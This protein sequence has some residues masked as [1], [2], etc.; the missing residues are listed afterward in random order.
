[1]IRARCRW[2]AVS[3]F[4]IRDWVEVVEAGSLGAC[5]SDGH[6]F[7]RL[8]CLHGLCLSAIDICCDDLAALRHLSATL[9]DQT[10]HPCKFLRL[11]LCDARVLIFEIQCMITRV[12]VRDRCVIGARL[13][14]GICCLSGSPKVLRLFIL[15]R[16]LVDARAHLRLFLVW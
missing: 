16:G 3:S 11:F 4:S 8:W 14:Y 9:S 12:S 1:M 6:R 13:D 7:V 15:S 5:R 2:P 10:L